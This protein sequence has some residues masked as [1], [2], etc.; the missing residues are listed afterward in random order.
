MTSV[1]GVRAA[2]GVGLVP[3]LASSLRQ[4]PDD[5]RVHEKTEAAKPGKKIYRTLNNCLLKATESHY[6]HVRFDGL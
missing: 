1:E 6:G 3:N 2:L 5:K 4:K